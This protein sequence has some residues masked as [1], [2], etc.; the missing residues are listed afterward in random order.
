M[1]KLN[2]KIGNTEPIRLCGICGCIYKYV[3]TKKIHTLC[4]IIW[5]NEKHTKNRLF[6]P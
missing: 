4:Q 5:A 3:W 6:K 2:I 1:D